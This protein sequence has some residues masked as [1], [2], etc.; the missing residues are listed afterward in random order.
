VTI[1]VIAP[2]Q[3]HFFFLYERRLRLFI[4]LSVG[5]KLLMKIFY[6]FISFF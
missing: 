3:E 4:V 1:E 2:L 6:S 5:K